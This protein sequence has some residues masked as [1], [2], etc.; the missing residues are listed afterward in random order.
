[1]ITIEIGNILSKINNLNTLI[2]EEIDQELSYSTGGFCTPIKVRSVFNSKNGITYTG[3]VPKIINI[4]KS[5]NIQ[6]EIIDKRIKPEP[7]MNFK[8][9]T[10]YT[11]RDYQKEIVDRI[12]SREIIIAATSSGKTFI[13]ANIINK[14]Q[15]GPVLIIAPKISLA[16]QLKN[17][18][19]KFFPEE[20]IGIL[21]GIKKDIQ[22]ITIGTPQS[23][24]EELIKNVKMILCDECHNLTSS[25]IFNLLTNKSLSAYY[26]YGMSAS[27]W[28]ENGEDILIEAA[29]NVRKSHLSINASK[30]IEKGQLTPCEI[31]FVKIN[32]DVEWQGSYSKT[33]DKVIVNNDIR[34]NKIIDIVKKS[35]NNGQKSILVLISKIKHGEILLEKLKNSISIKN[36]FFIFNRNRIF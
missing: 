34:N 10:E 26:K 5:Y 4:I 23:I 20:K 7:N 25:T 2:A 31:N 28:R 21:T 15:V 19:E 30:L 18:F 22:N 9:T 3:L 12:S 29:I 32:G 35:L 14:Y 13:M 27:P 6:Y 8:I 33:Y 17:E 1:M 24:P 16:V 11:M 36:I